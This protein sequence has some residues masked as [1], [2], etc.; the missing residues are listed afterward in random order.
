ML[1]EFRA[2]YVHAP[3]LDYPEDPGTRLAIGLGWKTPQYRL[4]KGS[5][6]LKD[7]KSAL[8]II[9]DNKTVL[10]KTI[11]VN[12]PLRYGGY[13]LYQKGSV[14]TLKVRVDG[15]P[16]PLETP[17]DSVVFI[18]GL[19]GPIK[20]KPVITGTLHRLDKEIEDIVP[21]TIVTRKTKKTAATR[22]LGRLGF[23]GSLRVD[24]KR[25]TMAG[26]NEGTVLQYRYDPGVNVLWWGAIFVLI[27]MVLRFYGAWYRAA[28]SLSETGG[29][30]LIRIHVSTVGLMADKARLIKRI[31]EA[32]TRDDIRPTPVLQNAGIDNG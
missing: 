1:D 4:E 2:E 18:P 31:E 13:T 30:V 17:T 25:L 23:Y 6:A 29:I 28:Y 24:G 21:Y 5:I 15:G 12:D 27:A 19:K 3:T 11:E 22:E 16:I 26:F 20:F 8:R 14:Q 10:S 7:T 32:L 9:K